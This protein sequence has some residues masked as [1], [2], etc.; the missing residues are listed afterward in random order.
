M[1]PTA[2]NEKCKRCGNCCRWDI[3]SLKI[4]CPF[5][6]KN[7]ICYL[8]RFRNFLILLTFFCWLGPF[9]R[10]KGCGVRPLKENATWLDR[11]CD[12]LV[13][14][15][16]GI[17]MFLVLVLV[18]FVFYLAWLKIIGVNWRRT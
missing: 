7:N 5:L 3:F 12:L 15:L 6:G 11:C 13:L 2:R 8:Y 14:F 4:R 9:I 18:C 1:V 16:V 17:S 10:R